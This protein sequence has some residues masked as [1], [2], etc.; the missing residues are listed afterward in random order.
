MRLRM[1]L[2]MTMLLALAVTEYRVAHAQEKAKPAA[3][4]KSSGYAA[5]KP[6]FGGACP[7]CPWGS[8]GDVVKEAVGHY[9]WDVQM[10]YYC[11]GGSTEA[12]IV[13][14]AKV[15]VVPKNAV[16][17]LPTPNGPVDFGAT[18][19]DFLQAAYLGIHDF[20]QDPEG[21][22]KQLRAVAFIQ[23]P[24][25]YLVAVKSN[26]PISSLSDIVNKKMAVKM[27][28]WPRGPRNITDIIMDYYKINKQTIEAQGGTFTNEYERDADVDVMFGFGSLVNAPEYNVWYH[29]T[30]KSDMKFIELAPDLRARLAKEFY[31]T[32]GNMQVGVLRG[33]DKP[34]NTLRELG[35]IIYGRTDMPD[36]FA[37]TLAKALDEHQELLQWANGSLNYSYNH[38][39][40]WKTMDIPLHPGAAKY[41]KEVGYM[42]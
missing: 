21:P 1:L 5:K 13:A 41:Y 4:A 22:R 17:P 39:N 16:N 33:V 6:V 19:A 29:L 25:Y 37:Y 15:P 23:Q 32:E 2:G 14:G 31:I 20:A 28:A 36:D 3:S 42:K 7:T 24:T 34:V 11:A 10:C 12:R 40:V 9:G 8:I 27:V 18:S 26:L 35:T 30:Q 38:H